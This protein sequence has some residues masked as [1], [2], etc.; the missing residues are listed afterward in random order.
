[1]ENIL[2]KLIYVILIKSAPVLF[3]ILL[4]DKTAEKKTE[5]L[6]LVL[7]FLKLEKLLS[8]KKVK[9]KKYFYESID[10]K[11]ISW[12]WIN[13]LGT[14]SQKSV[15]INIPRMTIIYVSCTCYS[16]L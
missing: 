4:S 9:Q 15:P 6:T 8:A 16:I 2:Y 7:P 5:T 13:G 11:G 1:M 14:H 10:I 3:N 12:H